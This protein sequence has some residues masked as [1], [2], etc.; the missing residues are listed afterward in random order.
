MR[1]ISLTEKQKN[2]L[3]VFALSFLA[4]FM[5]YCG[6]LNHS[7]TSDHANVF[8]RK[9]VVFG[10]PSLNPWYYIKTLQG[11]NALYN[12]T[13]YIFYLFGVTKD[14]N[15]YILQIYTFMMMA[16]ATSLLFSLYQKF[17]ESKRQKLL[18]VAILLISFINPYFC[19]V[20]LYIAY[21]KVYGVIAAIFGTILFS[22]KKYIWS[23]ILVMLAITSYQVNFVF[24]LV[25]A[26]TWIY[27]SA[28]GDMNKGVLL[29][30]LKMYLIMII[31]GS[32][33]V[34][35]YALYS[36]WGIGAY[37]GKII[38]LEDTFIQRLICVKN[39]YREIMI[40]Q[41]GLLPRYFLAISFLIFSILC[42]I[43]LQKK[44]VK[45]ILFTIVHAICLSLYPA[46][47][48]FIATNAPASGR[49]VWCS[50]AALAG[51]AIAM[52][53]NVD[54]KKWKINIV[55]PV[56]ALFYCINIYSVSSTITNIYKSNALDEQIIDQVVAQIENYERETGIS[57]KKI[58]A[59]SNSNSKYSYP[60]VGFLGMDYSNGDAGYYNFTHK[61]MKDVWADA[62]LFIY[63]TGRPYEIAY[64]SDDIWEEHFAGK[65][66]ETFNP[67]E[68]LY[69][70]GDTV[71]WCIY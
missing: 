27:L 10:R 64:I 53:M 48:F 55:I 43:F 3:L 31:P 60:Q 18:L 59:S 42:V 38:P 8:M 69:F 54:N 14:S 32:I 25:Y 26:S 45:N 24:F 20:L 16:F 58:A 44:S 36:K 12:W 4:F 11:L 52:L 34:L 1:K 9:D 61:T 21:E 29:S 71:Y 13:Q 6:F 5:V 17:F 57:I 30:Y 66:W 35:M 46:I 49:I 22:R 33:F 41:Q 23:F 68:Q 65:T 70:E 15:Q 28:K 47:L 63:I 37:I 40:T 62:E 2:N 51:V 56:V 7:F 50:F 39:R 19:E 67:Q